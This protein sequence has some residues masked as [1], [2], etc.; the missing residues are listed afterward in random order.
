MSSFFALACERIFIKTQSIESRCAIGPENIGCRCMRA[1]FSCTCC[2]SEGV[3]EHYISF[4]QIWLQILCCCVLFCC[5]HH[6]FCVQIWQC[7]GIIEWVP[8]S[9][10]GHI[11]RNFMP[12]GTGQ[13]KEKIAIITIVSS[14]F[15]SMRTFSGWSFAK[16]CTSV[17][18]LQLCA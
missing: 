12:Y 17:P 6:M 10:V 13:Q 15:Y 3:K 9:R 5:E 4:V 14:D 18:I 7:G 2:G 8:C 11:Y 16:D 1:F